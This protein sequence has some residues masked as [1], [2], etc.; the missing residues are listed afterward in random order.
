MSYGP[1]HEKMHLVSYVNNK[2]ADVITKAYGPGHE[3]T[4]L[5]LYGNNQ[6]TDVI[7]ARS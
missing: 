7:W 4:H 3:K 1:G 6:D 5:I 2:G